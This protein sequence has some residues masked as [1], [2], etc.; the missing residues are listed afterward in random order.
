MVS[1]VQ[2]LVYDWECWYE[3]AILLTLSNFRWLSAIYDTWAGK[4]AN[5]AVNEQSRSWATWYSA[6]KKLIRVRFVTK[7]TELEQSFKLGLLNE[8]SLNNVVFSLKVREQARYKARDQAWYK[9]RKQ[10]RL[11]VRKIIN[12]KINYKDSLYL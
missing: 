8:Q 4:P 12:Y 3:P 7:R 10:A 5:R 9:A 1:V 6:R 2:S 11:E